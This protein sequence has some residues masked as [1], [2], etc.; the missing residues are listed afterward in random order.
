M[1]SVTL[2]ESTVVLVLS[3]LLGDLPG[4]AGTAAASDGE[5]GPWM[6]SGS[7]V[8]ADGDVV[9]YFGQAVAL[10]GNTALVGAP[11]ADRRQ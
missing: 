4:W 10:D 2:L 7:I 5:E 8:S 1:L 3:L 11:S 6:L 9:D